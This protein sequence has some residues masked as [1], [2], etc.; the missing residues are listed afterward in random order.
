MPQ[1]L[2]TPD[3]R[4]APEVDASESRAANPHGTALWLLSALV[5]AAA[6]VIYAAF[7]GG[8][9]SPPLDG[10]PIWAFAAVALA[11]EQL[12]LHLRRRGGVAFS[13]VAVVLALG[14]LYL[15]PGVLILSLA[16][17]AALTRITRTPARAAM[18]SAS[19]LA[20]ATVAATVYTVLRFDDPFV[21]QSVIALVLAV[22]AAHLTRAGLGAMLALVIGGR[23]EDEGGIEA[24][25]PT[26]LASLGWAG[27]ALILAFTAETSTRIVAL[28]GILVVLT[29]ALAWAYVGERYRRRGLEL[30]QGM[31]RAVLSSAQTEAALVTMLE[32]A[33]TIFH[34]PYAE[35]ILLPAGD[36]EPPLRVTVG[37][38]GEPEVMVPTT[39]D[40]LAEA[41]VFSS[42]QER[43]TL[44]SGEAARG[45]IHGIDE[46]DQMVALVAPLSGENRVLGTIAIAGSDQTDGALEAAD[47]ELLDALASH[48]GVALEYGHVERSLA[49]L[50]EL[51]RKLAHQAY[52][53]SLTGLANRTLFLDLLERA[54]MRNTGTE[55]GVV[56][57]FADLDD[58]KSIN[59][60]FGHP[61]GDVVLTEVAR[62]IR[63]C[64]RGAD[65]S[66]RL[67]GD[68]FA[69]LIDDAPQL[70]GVISVAER[71]LRAL[72]LPIAHEGREHIVHGS[73]G[74][75]FSSI[76]STAEALLRDAD[77][78]MYR[79]KAAGKGRLEIF[80]ESMHS[81]VR[82]QMDMRTDLSRAIQ[83]DELILHYQP[84]VELESARMVGVEALVR[85]QH[86]DKGMV[87][88][89]E[90]IP[91]AEETGLIT[92]LGSWVI[93][94]ACEQAGRW[95]RRFPFDPPLSMNINVSASQFRKHELAEELRMALETNG[96]E[97]STITL[98]ITESVFKEGWSRI[99]AVLEELRQLG[100][101][102]AIDDFGEGYSSLTRLQEMPVEILKIPK[103][104]VD[105]LAGVSGKA[106]LA[107]TV[108]RIG[109]TIG[110]KTV[111]EGIET[112][113]KWQQLRH[114]GCDYGQGYLFG[115]PVEPNVLEEHFERSL[116]VMEERPSW[117][118]GSPAQNAAS[119]VSAPG[120]DTFRGLVA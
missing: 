92:A 99:L 115:R 33:R 80:E 104:F 83:N 4:I 63:R 30:G 107:R 86:P 64:L 32:R 42:S 13:P 114:L 69:V 52:H 93:V 19:A 48:V 102:L 12:N 15:N 61:V 116:A 36:D 37:A 46:A 24:A 82:R 14:L 57:L 5:A 119:V 54:L 55:G 39:R 103:P 56:V 8:A 17:A 76:D 74:I 10:M 72:A 79:A 65:T 70:R 22:G 101:R 9:A 66:A 25:L 47:V 38:G 6:F 49:Q 81:E 62:R 109:D 2:D 31:A 59:D 88:P 28:V 90:F 75:A 120:R 89:G 27:L 11:G 84:V 96:V 106:T 20:Q 108:V 91:L 23:R 73:V 97:P 18:A 7:I 78:A 29:A 100:V 44:V 111:A 3:T 41:V 16:A 34:C 43:G 50:G 68:E 45:V 77:I 21:Y 112:V 35:I 98:E 117:G 85:W 40:A 118:A 53:D 60:T 58:F 94:K 95:Q 51:E 26:A 67:G 110:M 87:S 113:E 1:T 71:I 105:D